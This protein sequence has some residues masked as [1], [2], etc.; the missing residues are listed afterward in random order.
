MSEQETG[1]RAISRAMENIMGLVDKT[2]TNVPSTMFA[3][4]IRLVQ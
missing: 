4:A 2:A 3:H 1:S